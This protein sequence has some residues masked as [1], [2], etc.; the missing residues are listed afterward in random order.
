M[1]HVSHTDSM[2]PRERYGGNTPDSGNSLRCVFNTQQPYLSLCGEQVDFPTRGPAGIVVRC[3]CQ[4]PLP[5]WVIL[6]NPRG[7]SCRTG[8]RQR[9]SVPQLHHRV[10]R[11]RCHSPQ[12]PFRILCHRGRENTCSTLSPR[13]SFPVHRHVSNLCVFNACL[14]NTNKQKVSLLSHTPSFC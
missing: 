13:E 3:W 2:W 1:D 10:A 6:G 5:V 4:T 7:A 12:R 8:D 9:V 14:I 11:H